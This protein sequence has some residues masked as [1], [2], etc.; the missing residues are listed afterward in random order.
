MVT[1]KN[2]ISKDT[3]EIVLKEYYKAYK[4]FVFNND[5]GKLEETEVSLDHEISKL[6]FIKNVVQRYSLNEKSAFIIL[7]EIDFMFNME[8]MKG[9]I[10]TI[11]YTL[12]EIQSKSSEN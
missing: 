2:D 1:Y 8:S 3:V 12:N 5:T 9:D 10:E 4:G 11:D 6:D 7:G